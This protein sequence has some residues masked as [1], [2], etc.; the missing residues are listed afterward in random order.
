MVTETARSSRPRDAEAPPTVPVCSCGALMRP[1]IVW[2][3]EALDETILA[4][5]L[6]AA[7]SCEALLVIGT[8]SVVHPAAALPGLAKRHG[9]I[10]VEVNVEETP[11]TAAAD[12]TLRGKSGE[13]LPAL[14]ALL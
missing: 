1:D 11:L 9:A 7:A 13:L 4:H 6:D 14:E 8:S 3:G 5:T 2:F 12:Y 10:V